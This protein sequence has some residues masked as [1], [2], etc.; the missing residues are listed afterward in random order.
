[1]DLVLI[2][3]TSFGLGGLFLYGIM[4]WVSDISKKSIE[5]AYAA[6]LEMRNKS[7]TDLLIRKREVYARLV[8]SMRVFIET[9][10]PEGDDL[11]DKLKDAQRFF[12]EAYDESCIWATNDVIEAIG[13]FLDLMAKNDHK[14]NSVDQSDIAKSY[15]NSIEEIRKDAVSEEATVNYRFVNFLK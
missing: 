2:I 11:K 10:E 6:R 14:S 12:L 7:D 4:R 5:Q 9:E 3:L 13:E 8:K 1:M 15:K